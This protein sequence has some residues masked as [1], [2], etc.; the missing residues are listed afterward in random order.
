LSFLHDYTGDTG[1]SSSSGSAEVQE[2]TER[3]TNLRKM[4]DELLG[5]L[6]KMYEEQAKK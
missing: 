3:C 4:N 5:M 1:P 2:L 6:E